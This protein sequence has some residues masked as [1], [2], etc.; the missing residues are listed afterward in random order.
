MDRPRLALL[1]L[2][3]LLGLPA[4]SQNPCEETCRHVAVCRREKQV[5]ER[6]LGEGAPVA[7]PTCLSRCAAATPEYA[8]CEGK[9]RECAAVLACVP[10]H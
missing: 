6:M 9:K 10:Y 8:A 5:G 2:C 4:C 1:G 3:L 7:D